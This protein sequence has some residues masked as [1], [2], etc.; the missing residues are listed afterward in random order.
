MVNEKLPGYRGKINFSLAR[1]LALDV[2]EF[3]IVP[4]SKLTG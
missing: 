4:T 2:P 1:Q 3:P